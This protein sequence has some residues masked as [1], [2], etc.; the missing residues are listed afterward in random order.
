MVESPSIALDGTFEFEEWEGDS[1]ADGVILTVGNDG[2]GTLTWTASV[3]QSWV[4]LSFSGG[5]LAPGG[6][7]TIRVTVDGSS[8]AAGTHTA[9]ITVSGN[10]DDSPQTAD[11]EFVAVAQPDLAPQDVADHL[12][13]VRTTL[14]ASDLEYLDEFGNDNGSFD[15]GD[16]RAWLQ[17][18]GLMSRVSP[19]AGEEVAP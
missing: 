11:E 19:A 6:A 1:P 13:G 17:R 5:T 2:G 4:D 15:V 9:V 18:E 7:S 3:D 14:S 10:A 16:F 8:L 12:M